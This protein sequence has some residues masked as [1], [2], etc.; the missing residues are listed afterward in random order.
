MGA[1]WKR[2]RAVLTCEK[3]FLPKSLTEV[4]AYCA[5]PGKTGRAREMVHLRIETIKVATKMIQLRV[6]PAY[7]SSRIYLGSH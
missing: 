6:C 3:N 7:F 1:I 5:N 4:Q 2:L